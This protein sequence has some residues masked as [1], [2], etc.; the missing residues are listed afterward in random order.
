MVIYFF[1]AVFGGQVFCIVLFL[2]GAS[3][4]GTLI[5]QVAIFKFNLIRS[6]SEPPIMCKAD[7]WPLCSQVND[8]IMTVSRES[9]ELED[10]VEDYVS[11]MKTYK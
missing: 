1:I 9:R 10:R 4:F 5:S 6:P 3:L 7:V 8:I 11:F 2:Y